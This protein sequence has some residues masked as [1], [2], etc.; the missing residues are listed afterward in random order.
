MKIYLYND[1]NTILCFIFLLTH[2]S[3][4]R[5][6]GKTK[7][8][9]VMSRDHDKIMDRIKKYDMTVWKY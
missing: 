8:I 2:A 7:S 4:Q 6:F 5:T 1:N 9:Q 3:R